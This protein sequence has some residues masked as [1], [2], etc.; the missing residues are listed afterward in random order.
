VV[1]GHNSRLRTTTGLLVVRDPRLPD[2]ARLPTSAE[3]DLLPGTIEAE[4]GVYVPPYEHPI[5]VK[6]GDRATFQVFRVVVP[7]VMPRGFVDRATAR[8]LARSSGGPLADVMALSKDDG[9][10]PLVLRNFLG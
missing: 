7:D 2:A 3:K 9:T 10:L 5:S 1:L 4:T 6:T 8:R